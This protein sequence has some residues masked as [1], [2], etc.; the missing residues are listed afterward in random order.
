MHRER[1]PAEK[2]A[3]GPCLVSPVLGSCITP[4]PQPSSK[5]RSWLWVLV[6]GCCWLSSFLPRI[7]CELTLWCCQNLLP[8]LFMVFTG[9]FRRVGLSALGEYFKSAVLNIGKKFT[10]VTDASLDS[11]W[12][13]QHWG[14]RG[15]EEGQAG[16]H[17]G[18]VKVTNGPPGSQSCGGRTWRKLWQTQDGWHARFNAQL[19]CS[20]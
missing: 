9:L 15:E 18:L 14:M 2:G 12:A 7:P 1:E 6:E 4:R 20:W 16:V 3:E 8:W 13:E 11:R 19:L 17:G 10:S 5:T